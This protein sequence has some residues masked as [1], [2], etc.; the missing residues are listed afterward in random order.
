MNWWFMIKKIC[1]KIV[2]RKVLPQNNQFFNSYPSRIKLVNLKV[3]LLLTWWWCQDWI[4]DALF[5][6]WKVVLWKWTETIAIYRGWNFV[7]GATSNQMRMK[8]CDRPVNQKN[9][10][11]QKLS[12][13]F[14][15]KT[16]TMCTCYS[17][18]LSHKTYIHISYTHIHSYPKRKA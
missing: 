17:K 10:N 14:S 2:T 13:V 11:L 16:F 1:H 12:T 15:N 5:W 9:V 18:V 6:P 7:T 8:K 4:I 3:L